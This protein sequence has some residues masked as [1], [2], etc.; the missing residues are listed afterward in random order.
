MKRLAKLAA[1]T[2]IGAVLGTGVP[3][4]AGQDTYG[5]PY[6]SWYAGQNGYSPGDRRDRRSEPRNY[7]HEGSYY[8]RGAYADSYVPGGR[9]E[10]APAYRSEDRGPDYDPYY[11]RTHHGRDA[12]IMLGG[13]AAGAVIGGAAGNARGAAIGA[14]VGGIAG[15]IA[16][17]ASDHQRN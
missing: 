15:A 17:S 9:Y 12:A 2:V 10:R 14:V 13:A 7:E 11:R 16:S 4:T 6:Q 5:R 1:V 8:Q 3:A